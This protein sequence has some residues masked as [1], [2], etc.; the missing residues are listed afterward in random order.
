MKRKSVSNVIYQNIFK[1]INSEN[2]KIFYLCDITQYEIERKGGRITED[3]HHA[4]QSL[5]NNKPEDDDFLSEYVLQHSLQTAYN[6]F[7]ELIGFCINQKNAQEAICK[8]IDYSCIIGNCDTFRVDKNDYFTKISYISSGPSY[9]QKINSISNIILLSDI[10]NIYSHNVELMVSLTASRLNRKQLFDDRF[11]HKCLINQNENSIILKN[12]SLEE[13]YKEYNN[14]LNVL[15]SNQVDGLKKSILGKE[16]FSSSV[17]EIIF[18]VIYSNKVSEQNEVLKILCELL[19]ISR[20]TLNRRLNSE[21]VN[22]T[23]LFLNAKINVSIKLL[24]E[25]N[26]SIQEISDWLAFSSH[27]AFSR[28]FKSKLGISPREYR[29]NNKN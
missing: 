16:S 27:S 17:S 22:Y 26:L 11:N 12:K 21:N 3:K 19:K 10:I 9:I 2:K 18:N 6:L 24:L 15:Q 20:W 1:N 23:I 4:L 29:S 28:F 14:I 5:L 25:T 7:P 8:F 13:E